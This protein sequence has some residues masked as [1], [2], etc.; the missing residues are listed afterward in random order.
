M[1]SEPA[2]PVRS[3]GEENKEGKFSVVL[4]NQPKTSFLK[5]Q[6]SGQISTVGEKNGDQGNLKRMVQDNK[7]FNSKKNNVPTDSVTFEMKAGKEDGKEDASSDFSSLKCGVESATYFPAQTEL[8]SQ[9][10]STEKSF[11]LSNQASGAFEDRN[12]QEKKS[13][14]KTPSGTLVGDGSIVTK[15]SS[16]SR[17]NVALIP[18]VTMHPPKS[19]VAQHNEREMPEINSSSP[20]VLPEATMTGATSM[21]VKTEVGQKGRATPSSPRIEEGVTKRFTTSSTK[22]LNIQESKIGKRANSV[23]SAPILDQSLSHPKTQISQIIPSENPKAAAAIG[24]NLA[25]VKRQTYVKKNEQTNLMKIL[26]HMPRIVPKVVPK[27]SQV[28]LTV[29]SKS[30]PFLLP[31][32]I[33]IGESPEKISIKAVELRRKTSPN[34]FPGTQQKT[35]VTESKPE[36][37]S[38][39]ED[40]NNT[41]NK[42]LNQRGELNGRSTEMS[43]EQSNLA[44]VIE[45]TNPA[46]KA[47]PNYHFVRGDSSQMM[48]ERVEFVDCLE[49]MKDDSCLSSRG[50]DTVQY[51][52]R[53]NLVFRRFSNTNYVAPSGKITREFNFSGKSKQQKR[54]R[55]KRNPERSAK[56]RK[57]RVEDLGC[58]R[59][60]LGTAIVEVPMNAVPGDKIVV[61]WPTNRHQCGTPQLYL[62][63]VPETVSSFKSGRKKR[64]LKVLAP[65]CFTRAKKSRH[66]SEHKDGISSPSK[67]LEY[68]PGFR[69]PQKE[70]WRNYSKTSSRVGYEYQVPALPSSSEFQR[71][72][73]SDHNLPVAKNVHTNRITD[74]FMVSS[75]PI[76]ITLGERNDF[77]RI[78]ISR[79][80]EASP[81]ISKVSSGDFIIAVDEVDVTHMTLVQACQIILER[82]NKQRIIKV[83]KKSTVIE[84]NTS[85]EDKVDRVN[86]DGNYGVLWDCQAAEKAERNGE[87]IDG[88][89]SKRLNSAVQIKRMELLHQSNYSVK[90]AE[91]KFKRLKLNPDW[92]AFN[93]DEGEGFAKAMTERKR[94]F[95]YAGKQLNRSVTACLIHYYSRF[96]PS[97]AYNILK[98]TFQ[99]STDEDWCA[100]CDDGGDLICCDSCTQWY[101]PSCLSPPLLGLPEGD[102]FCRSCSTKDENSTTDSV[103]E[104]TATYSE[105]RL[106]KN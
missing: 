90:E 61:S 57:P 105:H 73:S 96:K 5:I 36:R 35:W 30:L 46:A 78:F 94:D 39:G 19:T 101:H 14:G 67:A 12:S 84:S 69:S 53:E 100:I 77:P 17:A 97:A 9:R 55:S 42:R 95:S 25:N 47:W 13:K 85:V 66:H 82:S 22:S 37:E 4:D 10:L 33:V 88:F 3:L 99:A 8:H 63:Q 87:D 54:G 60:N 71:Q 7:L 92:I 31:K 15:S 65:D 48:G 70:R 98:E 58:P 52:S 74:V 102:W 49:E 11:S 38:M 6:H 50:Q 45:D 29:P 28:G 1:T 79:V 40:K 62:I 26:E 2:K 27:D 91:G 104:V 43:A 34:I 93:R 24:A 44:G 68:I 32:A 18:T 16:I 80:K 23:T 41:L 75:G 21:E 86:S 56:K 59:L 20:S 89:L 83:S 106:N 51:A 76:G 72:G 81:L 64:L 103:A